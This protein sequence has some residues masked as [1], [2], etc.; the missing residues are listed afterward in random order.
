VKVIAR[1]PYCLF[2]S[3]DFTATQQRY[4]NSLSADKHLV[5][6]A[7]LDSLHG[8]IAAETHLQEETRYWFLQVPRAGARYV[9]EIGYY[10]PDGAW[11]TVRTAEPVSTQPDR[12][13]EDQTV[14][15]AYAGAVAPAGASGDAGLPERST[16]AEFHR[17]IQTPVLPE[18][19]PA[20]EYPRWTAAQEEAL[21][22]LISTMIRREQVPG[23]IEILELLQRQ[24]RRAIPLEQE[25]GIFGP[26][27]AALGIS[28]LPP[29]QVPSSWGE[30]LPPR[31]GF[32][33]NVNAELII[34]GATEPDAQVTIGGRA[35]KL[36]PDGTFSYRFALPDG[37]YELP[38]QAT[39]ADQTDA[40]RA[41]LRFSR[42]T[43]YDR[44]VGAHPQDTALKPPAPENVA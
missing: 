38:A 20:V 40:R 30:R 31:K 12:P 11:I 1:D 25:I 26:S 44:E 16:P 43:R 34:Y 22:E 28:S 29:E 27:S 33:F 35:I 3:W 24:A 7:H 2:V 6:R 23:S 42:H 8:P 19:R 37:Y 41:E 21:T 4:F 5:L 18:S 9:V 14:R 36:R 39:S 10:L 15:F 13:S 32:W 17:T